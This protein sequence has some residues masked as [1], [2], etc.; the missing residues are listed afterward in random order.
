M[1]CTE[2]DASL[3]A[4]TEGLLDTATA[5]AFEQH[6]A[7]C[8]SCR[9]Q[10]ASLGDLQGQLV[11]CAGRASGVALAPAVV[12]RIQAKQAA[13][14]E[15]RWPA[16]APL[17]R[18][19]VGAGLAAAALV[20]ALVAFPTKGNAMAAEVL[21]RGITA[22]RQSHSVHLRT[23]VRA[24]AADNFSRIDPA[25]P[26]VSLELWKEF[27][28][29]KRWRVEKPGRV[30]IMDGKT[31]LLY[32]PPPTNTGMRFP[33]A[34]ASA[35]DTE[36]LHRMADIEGTLTHALRMAK[37]KNWK[38]A[39]SRETDGAGVSHAVITVDTV[40]GAPA[41]DYLANKFLQTA[42]L[43]QV[44]RFDDESGRL[45]AVQF[46]LREAAESRLV[47]E[48]TQID[49]N[50]TL[51]DELFQVAPS[52]NIVLADESKPAANSG[53]FANLTPAQ[54]ART[55]FEACGRRDW[56]TVQ[57]FYLRPVDERL[58]RYLGGVTLVSLGT[59]FKSAV[60]PSD[61]VPYE[62]QLA[63]GS[64]KK[65]NLALKKHPKTGGWFI[66]GGI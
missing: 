9:A 7:I 64:T 50:A 63:N 2:F 38:I 44:F 30:A 26:F 53:R 41:G 1:N 12:A 37:T 28:G 11:A 59:P 35:F 57:A 60:I 24:P 55:F 34:S 21:T 22:A 6:R 18:W 43:R 48:V 3:V 15:A 46:Y 23:F 62:I 31:T 36:W 17:T 56:E 8:A 39:L 47:F 42:D 65:H 58:Q 19:F 16:L 14:P 10:H 66:D 40:S 5:T 52:A 49:Y 51:A 45:E 4:Q 29:E 54:A 13:E 25:L 32:N 20:V 27:D 33:K 61:F